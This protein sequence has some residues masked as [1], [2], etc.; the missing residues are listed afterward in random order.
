LFSDMA[1]QYEIGIAS[2]LELAKLVGASGHASFR[3]FV[4]GYRWPVAGIVMELS[5]CAR[6]PIVYR[7]KE[8]VCSPRWEERFGSVFGWPHVLR[9]PPYTFVDL[10]PRA[11][12]SRTV[13]SGDLQ[14][15]DLRNDQ[16]GLSVEVYSN[17]YKLFV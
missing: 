17:S 1:A 13:V 10:G 11:Y 15:P 2:V 5:P 7:R 9:S 4:E 6:D 16:V 3:R 12:A 14:L 8:V